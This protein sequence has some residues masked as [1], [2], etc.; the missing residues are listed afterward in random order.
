MT[1]FDTL[2]RN[3]WPIFA[4]KNQ[5]KYYI[6]RKLLIFIIPVLFFACSEDKEDR[7]TH[8][9]SFTRTVPSEK[10][11][12]AGGKDTYVLGER[13]GIRIST[14]G[15]IPTNI[16]SFALEMKTGTDDRYVTIASG[17]STTLQFENLYAFKLGLCYIKGTVYMD[18]GRVMETEVFDFKVMGPLISDLIKKTEVKKH[19]NDCW[20]DTKSSEEANSRREFGFVVQMKVE[21]E[22]EPI[23][24]FSETTGTSSNDCT[25]GAVNT[26]QFNIDDIE[27]NT[28]A[29]YSVALFHTHPPL[30]NCPST[31]SRETGPSDQDNNTA[32]DNR[33]PSVVLDY[34]SGG[35]IYG[36]HNRNSF[37]TLSYAGNYTQKL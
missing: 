7:C 36:G 4:D 6:M 37:Y 2:L 1:D 11:T 10:W 29:S 27:N 34:G 14:G 31:S 17:Y 32:N 25:T 21:S 33:I 20:N 15:D 24:S 30:T 26:I 5:P 22:K 28:S 18:D 13:L 3:I 8:T 23:Y 9:S 19:M 16:S 12:F 35:I